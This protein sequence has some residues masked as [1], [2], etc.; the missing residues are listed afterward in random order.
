MNHAEELIGQGYTFVPA[1]AEL[2][3]LY[4][5]AHDAFDR[6]R[7]L[8]PGLKE[9]FT[10][11]LNRGPRR[12][13]ETILEADDGYIPRGGEARDG[14]GTYDTKDIWHYRSDLHDYFPPELK[15][16]ADGSRELFVTSAQIHLRYLTV[17][18][19]VAQSFDRLPR[20]QKL[21]LFAERLFRFSS[22]MLVLRLLAYTAKR[23][24]ARGVVGQAHQDRGTL[25]LHGFQNEGALQGLLNGQWVTIHHPANSVLFFP[26]MKAAL[27]TGGTLNEAGRCV[28]GGRLQ[29]LWHRG[30]THSES[31]EGAPRRV[32]VAFAHHENTVLF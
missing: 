24:E 9:R 20:S 10:L 3:G 4:E 12:D 6:F 16:L 5:S 8:D 11:S 22:E 27:A 17:L 14:G 28:E 30:L 26:G 31:L 23:S 13:R 18:N 25:T 21:N 7:R 2:E 15:D 19:R 32:V 29:A 1:D